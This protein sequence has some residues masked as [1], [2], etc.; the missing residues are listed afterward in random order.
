MQKPDAITIVSHLIALAIVLPIG[1]WLRSSELF[2]F[3]E[4]VVGLFH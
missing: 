3:G 1:W 4:W 2:G